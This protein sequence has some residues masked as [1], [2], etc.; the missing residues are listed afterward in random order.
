MPTH[1]AC[2]FCAR[3]QREPCSSRG[4]QD[5]PAEVNRIPEGLLESRRLTEGG[6]LLRVS[7]GE[8]R[9]EQLSAQFPQFHRSRGLQS[10]PFEQF[11]G[12]VFG[13]TRHDVR[14]LAGCQ[15]DPDIAF[16]SPEV[17]HGVGPGT[18]SGY[19]YVHH[20]VLCEAPLV[21]EARTREHLIPASLGGR[22][23]TSKALCR[24][25]N[26]TTGHKWDAELE[27]QLRPEAQFV[28]PS[29]HPR[30]PRPRRVVDSTGQH[31]VLEAGIR[32]G[33]VEPETHVEQKADGLHVSISARTRKR[34]LQELKRLVKAG[35]V[36]ADREEEFIASIEVG[37]VTIPVEFVE[38]G[39]FGGPVVWK[40]MLK[41]MVTTGLDC[42][43]ARMRPSTESAR[44]EDVILPRGV[45]LRVGRSRQGSHGQ[46]ADL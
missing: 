19:S 4:D 43:S 25:C 41:T 12:A 6:A 35:R 28:F 44:W 20:C 22:R 13:G 36:P 10:I 46:F 23:R 15:V 30:G 14:V 26:S 24:R 40:S 29:G 37:E 45:S 17:Q 16:A 2:G 39:R 3:R 1:T 33:A 9:T 21:G 7:V 8:Q 11:N 34:A 27:L 42:P 18:S 32:G 38:A 5:L 31:L